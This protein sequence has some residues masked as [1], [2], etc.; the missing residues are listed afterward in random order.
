MKEGLKGARAR[1]QEFRQ[2]REWEK[3]HQPKNVAMSISIEAAELMELF[4]WKDNVA[5]E[6]I[7]EDK[8]LMDRIKEELADIVLYCFS[9]ADKLDIELSKA[10]NDKLDEN[11]ERFDEETSREIKEEL[12]NWRKED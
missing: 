11:M 2:N 7:K 5:V 9:M 12:E 8:Q 10:V 1:Y 6:K 3:F 4:Q